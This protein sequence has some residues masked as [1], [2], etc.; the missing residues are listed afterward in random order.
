MTSIKIKRCPKGTR[1][2]KI[3]G[4]CEKRKRRE[5]KKLAKKLL[6]VKKTQK[7]KCHPNKP[8]YNPKTNRCVTDTP[9][10]RV[11][12]AKKPSSAKP[13]SVKSLIKL[14]VKKT[15][16]KKCPPHKPL[17][18][19]KTNR[20]VLDTPANRIK[21]AK[22]P[23][24]K[25]PSV[26]S[27]IKLSPKQTQ[28]KK[29]P[30]HKPLY[31]PKTNHCVLDTLANREKINNIN[32]KLNEKREDLVPVVKNKIQ[33][34]TNK[35]LLKTSLGTYEVSNCNKSMF[36]DIDLNK[37]KSINDIK[38]D[39]FE[40]YYL[41]ENNEK[42]YLNKKQFI[43]GGSYGKVYRIY[44][45][46]EKINVALKT[47]NNPKDKEVNVIKK[48]NKEN[49]NCNI[50]GSKIFKVGADNYVS[51]CELYSDSLQK[52]SFLKELNIN[53]KILIIKQLAKDLLC[54]YKK[55]YF[56][57]DIKL[58]NTLYKCL[59]NKKIKVTLGDVGS[60]CF[61]K[62]YCTVTNM[63]FEFKHKNPRGTS[64]AIVW[65]LGIM[66]LSMLH[67]EGNIK[68]FHWSFVRHYDEGRMYKTIYQFVD[69]LSTTIKNTKITDT[70]N[71]YDLF[72]KMLP[73]I[74]SVRIN[75]K[76]LVKI[77]NEYN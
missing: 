20:C 11:K 19:P 23:P 36:K 40:L 73:Y 56:Y 53:S 76:D 8:L 43:A 10:N 71:V 33:K 18:N 31:N 4:K 66:F 25:P 63:P 51:V 39:I 47:Y 22:K 69:S 77:L 55:G 59:S 50:L 13:S 65:G 58:A 9:A 48:L 3:T 28:K 6:P 21:L 37:I 67:N 15:Q 44:D 30:P 45:K 32:L 61:K 1:K 68:E 46:D 38:N 7:K 70:V 14:P 54:L 72:L 12:L 41:D 34:R 2:N 74:P 42:I 49:I 24:V 75:I 27:L 16:K 64:G 60:I 35:N 57:T 5:I 29:C 52:S 26:K 17:Y 62:E